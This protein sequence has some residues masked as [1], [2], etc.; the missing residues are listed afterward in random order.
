MGRLTLPGTLVEQS[1]RVECSLGVGKER[2]FPE[3]WHCTGRGRLDHQTGHRVEQAAAEHHGI[4]GQGIQRPGLSGGCQ[5][6]ISRAETAAGACAERAGLWQEIGEGL[7]SLVFRGS[8]EPGACDV[9]EEPKFLLPPPS[10]W[11][12]PKAYYYH[13]WYC[14][15]PPPTSTHPGPGRLLQ[16]CPPGT[17]GLG[18]CTLRMTR[19]CAP[20]GVAEAVEPERGW[21]V[22]SGKAH[23]K[24]GSPD[25]KAYSQ[26]P[27]GCF[28]QEEH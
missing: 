26:R 19:V 1:P 17:L 16:G 27:E 3:P 28:W 14:P 6:L 15:F 23:K 9:L 2:L 4:L 10:H 5:W 18:V 12:A 25:P 13:D 11:L 24:S 21:G 8:G 7:P 22:V 20:M